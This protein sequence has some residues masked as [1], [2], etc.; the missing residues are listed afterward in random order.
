MQLKHQYPSG[1]L[2]S[3]SWSPDVHQHHL[4]KKAK[5]LDWS[6]EGQLQSP[7]SRPGQRSVEQ[8]ENVLGA[9][10]CSAA[11]AWPPWGGLVP[12]RDS[13]GVPRLLARGAAATG[14]A[15]PA[16]EPGSGSRRPLV[17]TRTPLSAPEAAQPCSPL[18]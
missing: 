11:V 18:A 10:V 1:S 9:A 12:G 15:F 2:R 5:S 13:G 14:R 4:W 8:E 7:Q 3:P 17:W 16:S 6:E